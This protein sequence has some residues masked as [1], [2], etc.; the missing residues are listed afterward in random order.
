MENPGEKRERD[1]DAAEHRLN[2][3]SVGAAPIRLEPLLQLRERE[4]HQQH[5]GNAREQREPRTRARVAPERA[6]KESVGEVASIADADE[7]HETQH[8]G[9]PVEQPGESDEDEDRSG[10]RLDEVRPVAVDDEA[11]GLRGGEGLRVE[12]DEGDDAGDGERVARDLAQVREPASDAVEELRE[13][14]PPQP[15]RHDH[16]RRVH[17]KRRNLE[18]GEHGSGKP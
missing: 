5:D 12:I 11:T 3:L 7:P 17:L 14:R 2:A 15:R 16:A 8:R 13:R 18:G 4:D 9:R 1:D 6:R 10:G